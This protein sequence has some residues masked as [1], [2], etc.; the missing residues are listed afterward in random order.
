MG[1]RFK[2]FCWRE[3][4]Q[5]EI[6]TMNGMKHNRA[7]I[8]VVYSHHMRVGMRTVCTGRADN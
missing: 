1:Y 6:Q 7:I 5:R 8:K 4:I 2:K 3:E